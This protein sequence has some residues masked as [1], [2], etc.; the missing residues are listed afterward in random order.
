MKC[1]ICKSSIPDDSK[2]CPDCGTPVVNI[3]EL[4]AKVKEITILYKK[5]YE[6]YVNDGMLPHYTSNL[7][8][9]NCEKII[10][11][12]NLIIAK[13]QELEQAERELEYENISRKASGLTITYARGYY[14]YVSK[15]ILP[16]FVHNIDLSSCQLILSYEPK[17]IRKHYEILDEEQ[18]RKNAKEITEKYP[19][20]YKYYVNSG[21][22]P[23]FS[24]KLKIY[25][26][27]KI[28]K[29]KKGIINMDKEVHQENVRYEFFEYLKE[30]GLYRRIDRI[31]RLKNKCQGWTILLSVLVPFVAIVILLFLEINPSDSHNFGILYIISCIVSFF[32]GLKISDKLVGHKLMNFYKIF[33]CSCTN[34]YIESCKDL[35]ADDISIIKKIRDK[36]PEEYAKY[37]E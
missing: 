16:K 13:H 9:T 20:G 33:L 10:D 17:I 37:K 28:I 26:C 24:T 36:I 19:D 27:N 15:G 18:A 4:R 1:P 32:V 34:E 35:S 8:A 7:T 22:L 6:F 14:Y 5:G 11:N 12:Q 25:S 21:V 30:K 3:E 29:N 31:I 23:P 2:F